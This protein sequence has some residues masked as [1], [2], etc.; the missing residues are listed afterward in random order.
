MLTQHCL[1][2]VDVGPLPWANIL[3]S[4]K[5]FLDTSQIHCFIFARVTPCHIYTVIKPCEKH[6]GELALEM[7]FWAAIVIA[8]HAKR[9]ILAVV[10]MLTFRGICAGGWLLVA[11]WLASSWA[12]NCLLITIRLDLELDRK[13]Q[14]TG[15][16]YRQ[17]TDFF[18]WSLVIFAVLELF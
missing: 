1:C 4:I 8:A 10:Y 2:L 3:F 7:K 6:S 17:P 9:P 15:Y 13:R 16:R 11:N 5:N 18:L 14:C 12:G